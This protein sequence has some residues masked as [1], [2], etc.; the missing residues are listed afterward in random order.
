MFRVLTIFFIFIAL[1]ILQAG[2]NQCLVEINRREL[3]KNYSGAT[4]INPMFYS[5]DRV[6]VVIGV[7]VKLS[8]GEEMLILGEQIGHGHRGLLEKSNE[9]GETVTEILWAGEVKLGSDNGK[10]VVEAANETAGLLKEAKESAEI[11]RK[12]VDG[13]QNAFSDKVKDSQKNLGYSI[14]NASV[15]K[16]ENFLL[17][18]PGLK[19]KKIKFEAY[20]PENLQHYD[21]NGPLFSGFRHQFRQNFIDILAYGRAITGKKNIS[22][23]DRSIYLAKL[24]ESA[25]K[26]NEILDNIFISRPQL[27][28]SLGEKKLI[29]LKKISIGEELSREEYVELANDILKF[30]EDYS[31][32]IQIIK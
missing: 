12:I 3:L 7:L 14:G 8:S 22:V 25:R 1:P 32:I 28:I 26:I 11:I 17:R 16:L 27:K 31:E 23:A 18:H 13:P 6:S 20:D 4:H 19:S 29:A 2:P 30:Y 9:F 15:K 5:K 24:K 21:K 10:V